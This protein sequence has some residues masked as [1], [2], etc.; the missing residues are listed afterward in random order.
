MNKKTIAERIEF[1]IANKELVESRITNVA[2]D[3]WMKIKLAKK[4]P[5]T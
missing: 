5:K 4:K 2:N 3:A 1:Y